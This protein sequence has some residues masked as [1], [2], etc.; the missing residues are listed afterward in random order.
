MKR[1]IFIILPVIL[2]VAAPTTRC[3]A[4]I[5]DLIQQAII[6]AIK[7]ADIAVQKVQNT[8]LDLQNAQKMVEDDLS[9]LSLA[10]IGDWEQKT[11][12]LYS[13]YFS[14]LWQVKS[15]ISYF[16]Q[17]TG[18]VAQQS[19]LALEYKRAYSLVQQDNHFT[20]AEVS[21]IYKVYSGIIAE[22]VKSVDEI[23]TVLTSF[24]LQMSDAARLKIISR[25]S[26]DIER[27]TGDLRNFNN[28][29]GQVSLQRS[30]SLQEIST[31]KSLYGITD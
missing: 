20:P 27:D 10:Q 23:V 11:K 16:Q 21:Y 18:I 8:T 3:H 26:A 12:D 4:Q 29:T 25:A 14:E 24:S 31:I 5:F 1:L 9:Q 2:L 28:Q 15:A 7:A 13:E 22:S 17:I 19:Q 30:Q 6:A